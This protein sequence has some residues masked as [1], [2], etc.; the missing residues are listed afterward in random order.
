MTDNR[1]R[2]IFCTAT[3]SII[4]YIRDAAGETDALAIRRL[5]P[6]YGTALTAMPAAEAQA[7]YENKYKTPVREVSAED[8]DD[9]LNV[10][11]PVGW[12]RLRG[13]ESFKI[14]ERIA[15]R[16]TAIYVA[17]QGRHFRFDD[18]IRT[19]HKDCLQ[20]VSQFIAAAPTPPGK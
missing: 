15:G 2:V 9:A 18:D 1:P 5:A 19:P 7:L 17:L 8:F 12:S 4:D 13:G 11:P 10:L 6:E 16:V 20:R 14:S 3:Q